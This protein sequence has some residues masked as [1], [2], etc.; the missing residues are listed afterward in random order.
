MDH[1]FI[2]TNSPDISYTSESYVNVK[3]YNGNDNPFAR[4]E[5]ELLAGLDG[6]GNRDEF[7][8][9]HIPGIAVLKVLFNNK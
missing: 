1:I 3:R 8:S 2:K 4:T 9:D 6:K 7:P 5:G